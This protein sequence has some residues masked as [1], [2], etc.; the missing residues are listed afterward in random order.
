VSLDTPSDL[1]KGLALKFMRVVNNN[2]NNND[3]ESSA[4]PDRPSSSVEFYG[5]VELHGSAD[6]RA[7]GPRSVDESAGGLWVDEQDVLRAG[8]EMGLVYGRSGGVTEVMRVEGWNRI[9]VSV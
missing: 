4:L 2:N 9:K 7:G 5:D 8:S 3:V 6:L 1:R